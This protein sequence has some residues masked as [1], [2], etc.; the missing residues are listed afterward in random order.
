[1]KRT[2]VPLLASLL[3]AAPVVAGAEVVVRNL[4]VSIG[5]GSRPQR[6]EPVR[7]VVYVDRKPDVIYVHEDRDRD[8]W[9]HRHHRRHHREEW[10]ERRRWRDEPKVV[11]I[12]RDRGHRRD[13]ERRKVVIVADDRRW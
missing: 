1:M 11:I 8:R 7:E 12:D 6:H 4:D 13:D 5:I 2:L 9:E 3:L 10:R